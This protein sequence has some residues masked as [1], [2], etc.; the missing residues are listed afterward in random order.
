MEATPQG[1]MT[2]SQGPQMGAR[3]AQKASAMEAGARA[4]APGW[5]GDWRGLSEDTVIARGQDGPGGR[6]LG[7]RP[8]GSR[9]EATGERDRPRSAT[10][11][12]RDSGDGAGRL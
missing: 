6:R 10:S 3:A 2:D 4:S 12:A 11:D 1:P 7:S 8:L 5:P 9:R